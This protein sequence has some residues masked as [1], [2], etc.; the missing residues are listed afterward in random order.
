MKVRRMEKRLSL[1]EKLAIPEILKGLSITFRNM[2]R[3]KVTRQYPEERYE[4]PIAL[5]GQPLLVENED[6]TPRCVACSMCEVVCPAMAI[7]IKAEETERY[8]EREP[9]EFSIDMLR[10][11][12]CGLCEEVCPK[13]AIIMSD[14]YE[15]ANFTRE[16]L[17]FH[18]DRL[19]TP[20]KEL[21]GRIRFTKEKFDK[22]HR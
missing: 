3:P 15:L 1:M 20:I 17:V 4:A 22:W 10:C 11:I 8:I 6:G 19:M 7:T 18:K 9:E 16:S 13:E 21:E 2:F 5:K 12:L 14:R